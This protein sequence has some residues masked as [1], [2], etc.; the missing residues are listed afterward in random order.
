MWVKDIVG[1]TYPFGEIQKDNKLTPPEWYMKRKVD[2]F[3]VEQQER[4]SI[5]D[6][7]VHMI[8]N[9]LGIKNRDEAYL[10]PVYKVSSSAMGC[11]FTAHCWIRRRFVRT[12]NLGMI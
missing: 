11:V 12:R 10:E 7:Y 1:M 4:W 3:S 6:S 2:N 9:R 5:Y 8:N